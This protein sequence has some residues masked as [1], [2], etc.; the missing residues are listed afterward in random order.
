MTVRAIVVAIHGVLTRTTEPSWPDHLNKFLADCKVERRDYFAFPFPRINV[1]LKNRIHARAL[2]KELELLVPL[3]LP[4]NFVG[5]SNG[6]DVM[7]KTIR[8]LAER[9]IK[10]NAAIFVG[11]IVDPDVERSGLRLLVH[12][13]MLGRAISYSSMSDV[14][15]RLPLKFP[16]RDLG[17]VGWR[18]KGKQ[19]EE[20]KIFTRRF[21]GFGHGDYFAPEHRDRVFTLMRHDMGL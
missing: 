19:Y 11:S 17:R 16:Y 2:A 12:S 15:L 18:L 6:T 9:R 13:G 14:P 20:P 7:L 3:G 5:H 1:W 8:L 21:N 10:T 4:I